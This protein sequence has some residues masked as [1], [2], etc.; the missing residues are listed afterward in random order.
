MSPNYQERAGV[1][2]KDFGAPILRLTGDGQAETNTPIASDFSSAQKH[3]R[4]GAP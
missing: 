3:L 2:L 1:L 4:G